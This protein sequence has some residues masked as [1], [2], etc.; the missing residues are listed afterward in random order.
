MH[1]S[2]SKIYYDIVASYRMI[3]VITIDQVR[4]GT[5]LH[6]FYHFLATNI[7]RWLSLDL[8]Q[9]V[10]SRLNHAAAEDCKDYIHDPLQPLQL[11]HSVSIPLPRVPRNS[12]FLPSRESTLLELEALPP[13][14]QCWS[15]ARRSSSSNGNLQTMPELINIM[16]NGWEL[17]EIT[18]KNSWNPGALMW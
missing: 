8:Y 15:L 17:L 11:T 12:H 1:F 7:S 16:L 5:I 3:S 6:N 4:N 10:R 9:I 2:T 13:V 18:R 14:V